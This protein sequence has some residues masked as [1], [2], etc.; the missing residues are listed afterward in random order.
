[1]SDDV[2]HECV[3]EK[4]EAADHALIRNFCGSQ[5]YEEHGPIRPRKDFFCDACEKNIPRGSDVKFTIKAYGEDG[6]WPTTEICGTCMTDD[7]KVKIA[8][9]RITSGEFDDN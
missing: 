4:R 6:D 3:Y 8:Y 9:D 1:M 7:P 2:E 5:V